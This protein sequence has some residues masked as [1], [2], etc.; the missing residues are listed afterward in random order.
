MARKTNNINCF[1][2][3]TKQIHSTRRKGTNYA[4][5]KNHNEKIAKEKN[6]LCCHDCRYFDSGCYEYIGKYHKICEDFQWW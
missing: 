6:S 1:H 5:M 4:N 2:D 3:F